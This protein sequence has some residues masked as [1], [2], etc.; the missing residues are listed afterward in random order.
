MWESGSNSN[1]LS[2][3]DDP[4]PDTPSDSE[5][6]HCTNEL[7]HVEDEQQ[8]GLTDNTNTEE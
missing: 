2:N 8:Q 5:D 6:D 1:E 3:P 4:N 7:A